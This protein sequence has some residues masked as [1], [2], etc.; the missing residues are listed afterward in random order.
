MGLLRAA[1]PLYVLGA[2]GAAAAL[3]YGVVAS[4]FKEV[5]VA[6]AAGSSVVLPTTGSEVQV[7]GERRDI[8]GR[9]EERCVVRPEGNTFVGPDFGSRTVEG[10]Q[11][12]G[13]ADIKR[14]WESGARVTCPGATYVALVS[15]SRLQQ[16]GFLGS[17]ALLS[18]GSA[19]FAAVGLASRRNLRRRTGLVG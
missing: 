7:Y 1:V 12:D 11:V 6:T 10:R 5:V 14:G 15:G 17:T 16:Y 3:A 13:L 18:L 9:A 8:P 19:L 2:L 4:P